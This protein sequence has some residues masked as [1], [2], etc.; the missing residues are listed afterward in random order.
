VRPGLFQ[1]GCT[2]E[3]QEDVAANPKTFDTVMFDDDGYLI[4]KIHRARPYGWRDP[5]Y[6]MVR[7][8]DHTYRIF[9]AEQA[10][11]EANVPSL[12]PHLAMVHD[13]PDKRDARDVQTIGMMILSKQNGKQASLL[14]EMPGDR[15]SAKPSSPE[16]GQR[17]LRYQRWLAEQQNR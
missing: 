17:L 5:G 8:E 14:L 3:K 7:K 2:M 13:V 4:C 11:R 12:P 6:V 15:G 10:R 9:D 16:S 1:C